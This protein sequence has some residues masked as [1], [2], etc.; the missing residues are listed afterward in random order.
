MYIYNYYVVAMVSDTSEKYIKTCEISTI[1]EVDSIYIIEDIAKE[2][3]YK[4]NFADVTILNF[5][6][7]RCEEVEY[8]DRYEDYPCRVYMST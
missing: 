2:I 8:D 6:L 1:Y 3:G 5:K 7:L 4:N